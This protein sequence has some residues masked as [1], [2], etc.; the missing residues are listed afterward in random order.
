MQTM[1]EN[2]QIIETRVG[3]AI[4]LLTLRQIRWIKVCATLEEA[5][6]LSTQLELIEAVGDLLARTQEIHDA[7]GFSGVVPQDY[8][9]DAL[10]DKNFSFVSAY[11]S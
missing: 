11:K 3:E 7:R 10:L 8:N 6:R 5:V 2:C 4:I 1:T 9:I